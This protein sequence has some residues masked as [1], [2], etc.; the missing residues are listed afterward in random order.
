MQ[1][2]QTVQCERIFPDI[3]Q[4]DLLKDSLQRFG[5][6]CQTDNTNRT[7]SFN[8]LRDIVNNI[9]IAKDWSSKCVNQ[10]KQIS[11]QLG[12]Y[13]QVNYMKYKEDQN[14]LP[15]DFAN[16]Q[17][18]INDTTL[19]ASADLFQSQFAPTL[20][21]PYI[22]GNIAQIRM[23]DNTTSNTDF[24]IGVSPRILIDQKVNLPSG[25]TVT[26]TDGTKQVVINDVIS[27]PYFYK[28]EGEYSLCFCDMP[29]IG[30]NTMPGLNTKYYPEFRKILSQTK[31]TTRYMLLTPKDI[32][33]LDL[34]IPI[35]LQ[36]DNVY[37]YINKIDS[38]RKGQ[39][40]K[41]ELV[42]LG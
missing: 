30:G 37:Y 10:G 19:A 17:I 21:R 38:W 15:L 7:I 29:G 22:T 2:G 42:K 12:N 13:A 18:N 6:I 9:P 26:L 20:N 39:P 34:L 3:S 23:I 14:V 11:F 33:D 35:Y 36:Q 24:T 16:S 1:Y 27:T 32:L 41:V 40:C 8:S 5:I 31:K 4:K 28:P 25:K